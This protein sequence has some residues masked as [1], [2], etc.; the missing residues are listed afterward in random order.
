MAHHMHDSRDWYGALALGPGQPHAGGVTE[1]GRGRNAERL[2]FL[3][4]QARVMRARVRSA[5][6]SG[7]RPLRGDSASAN[8]TKS[9]VSLHAQDQSTNH[10]RATCTRPGCPAPGSQIRDRLDRLAPNENQSRPL[11]LIIGNTDISIRCTDL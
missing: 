11:H 5:D 7:C 10:A 3:R 1:P 6:F 8:Q 2:S 9:P 4:S